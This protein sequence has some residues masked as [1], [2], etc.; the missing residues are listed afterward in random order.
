MLLCQ[1]LFLLQSFKECIQFA[2]ELGTGSACFENLRHL[3]KE[4]KDFELRRPQPK[5]SLNGITIQAPADHSVSSQEIRA[6]SD[7]T[8]EERLQEYEMI[9]AGA[10]HAESYPWMDWDLFRRPKNLIREVNTEMPL[11]G[12]ASS[13]IRDKFDLGRSQGRNND[14]LGVFATRAL[15]E[16][17]YLLKDSTAICA[18]STGDPRYE[19][20]HLC[21][22]EFVGPTFDLEC[23]DLQFCSA[24]CQLLA[25]ETYHKALCGR[26]HMRLSK[27]LSKP[28]SIRF[29]ADKAL[30]LRTLAS[31]V[32]DSQTHPLLTSVISRMTAQ[33]GSTIPSHF[34]LRHNIAEP[35][36]V[37]QNLGVDIFADHRYDTWVLQTI[38]WRIQ[39]NIREEVTEDSHF[40]AINPVYLF[41][42][43]SCDPNVSVEMAGSTK[44][45]TLKFEATRD[46]EAGEELFISYLNEEEL[47]LNRQD[48]RAKLTDWTG[49]A[50]RCSR[51]TREDMSEKRRHPEIPKLRRLCEAGYELEY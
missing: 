10:V 36:A 43:H 46:V 27:S 5:Q 8:A 41:F 7:T 4:A 2:D 21:C 50:C 44:R 25:Y 39:T 29:Q 11:C 30:V 34:T 12:V 45:H 22:E 16:G 18:A 1:T 40:V 49:S 38:H 51:C 28:M 19:Y 48:R 13:P 24:G 9:F 31:V 15:E 47:A 6:Q 26:D 20:C 42:N 33:Y 37:L 32:S 17:S 35:F 23:C 14:V 3:A